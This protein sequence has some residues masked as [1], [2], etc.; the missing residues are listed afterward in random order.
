MPPK[1]FFL[2]HD[3]DLDCPCLMLHFQKGDK[4]CPNFRLAEIDKYW[5]CHNYPFIFDKGES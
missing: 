1:S 5:D 4:D 3:G 2:T